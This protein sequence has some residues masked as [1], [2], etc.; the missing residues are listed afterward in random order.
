MEP[1]VTDSTPPATA[2]TEGPAATVPPVSQSEPVV[3]S[4]RELAQAA[5]TDQTDWKAK[6]DGLVGTY[7]AR[8]TELNTQIDAQKLLVVEWKDK[9]TAFETQIATLN[10]QLTTANAFKDQVTTLTADKQAATDKAE[11]LELLTKFPTLLAAQVKAADG[12][13]TNPMLDLLMSSNLPADQLKAKA[14]A[15]AAGLP[16]QQPAQGSNLPPM[17]AAAPAGDESVADLQARA[18][19]AHGRWITSGRTDAAAKAEEDAAW[20][21]HREA[22]KKRA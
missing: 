9:A 5:P 1:E 16:R 22:K 4:S 7:R 12:T 13:V 18:M 3:K 14:E 15:L 19:E 11:R 10:T 8:T 21:L 2:T 20:A 6:Y 17:P